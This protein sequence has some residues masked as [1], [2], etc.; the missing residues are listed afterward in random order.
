MAVLV[1]VSWGVA[2]S[3]SA[4]QWSKVYP[5][6]GK[7]DLWLSTGDGSVRVDAWDEPRIEARI[8][9]VGYEI[10]KD[11]QVI[12]SQS[13]DRVRIELKFPRANWGVNIG[14]HSVTVT[15]K[16]PRTLSLD[17]HTGDGSLTILGARGDLR[18]DTGDGGIEARGLD[19]R[20]RASTG[21]GSMNVEGRFDLL[22]LHTGDGTIEA[23]ARGGSTVAESWSVRT[24]DGSVTLRVPSDFKATLD[25]STG[26]GQVTVDVPLTVSGVVKSRRVQGALNGGGGSLTLR[27]G[28]GGIRIA[29]Y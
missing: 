12:E 5:V 15:V 18:F 20:L 4:D 1:A 26:D 17:A 27:T 11:F 28:D 3:A 29:Q 8:D 9:T 14:R 10:N 22:D 24:G 13:G 6:S 19:G 21:D 16:V 7:P 25:A 2:A 23:A